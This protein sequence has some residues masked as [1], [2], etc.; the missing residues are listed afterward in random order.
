MLR[1]QHHRVEIKK[2]K[3]TASFPHHG[4]RLCSLL[5]HRLHRAASL[6][7]PCLVAA[8]ASAPARPPPRA[9]LD[10]LA[11]YCRRS[12]TSVECPSLLPMPR[13][14]RN[15]SR[16][17]PS[18]PSPAASRSCATPSRGQGWQ[19]IGGAARS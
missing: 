6:P 9:P 19:S 13:P 14:L 3:N 17:T 15:G 5:P 11:L 8:A 12:P 7:P 1:L 2:K 18:R 16:S 10:G 4:P